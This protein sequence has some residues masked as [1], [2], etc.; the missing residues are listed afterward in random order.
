MQ[1]N[2]RIYKANIS[3]WNK[4]R[5]TN[6][7]FI[8]KRRKL[9]MVRKKKCIKSNFLVTFFCFSRMSCTHLCSEHP[10][11]PILHFVHKQIVSSLLLSQKR[12]VGRS[13]KINR[14][15]SDKFAGL[16]KVR[17]HRS[18]IIYNEHQSFL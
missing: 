9:L 8:V 18:I 10:K 5:L 1:L 16:T 17:Q 13:V 15:H 2:V 7:K 4:I 11:S 12:H 14:I 3:F 6:Y